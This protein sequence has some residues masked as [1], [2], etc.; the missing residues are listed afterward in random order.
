MLILIYC[1]QIIGY[2]SNSWITLFLLVVGFTLSGCTPEKAKALSFAAIQFKTESL[3]AINTIDEM[4]QREIAPVSR[5]SSVLRSSSVK[6]ILAL[7]QRN[8]TADDMDFAIDPEKIN[9]DPS[10]LENRDK[11][12]T[13]LRIQYT[14][15]SAIFE[16]LE[17][18]N[19][20]AAPSV[21]KSEKHAKNLTLQMAVFA[22][23]IA[24]NPPQLLQER[25]EIII[26]INRLRRDYQ[27]LQIQNNF[28]TDNLE[29][30]NKKREIE[31]GIGDLMDRWQQ[32]KINEQKLAEKTIKQ[33][34]RVATLGKEMSQLIDEYDKLKLDDLNFFINKVL[35]V[36][37]TITGDNY[38]SLKLK[39]NQLVDEI[40]SDP[41]FN[42][43]VNLALENIGN[44]AAGR[45]VM[46][47]P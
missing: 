17:K 44:A 8:L 10:V 21:R 37:S 26:N 39:A 12:I 31:D 15:F 28:S 30:S 14:G 35:G 19:Y 47:N 42:E 45:T 24:K 13:N 22:A 20:L 6:N 18:G 4:Y 5:S 36:V 1:R 41:D 9:L 38:D 3:T 46:P 2:R 33:C 16:K 23:L 32:N 34:L 29:T 27:T 7:Q 25:A 11:F 40:K 43:V